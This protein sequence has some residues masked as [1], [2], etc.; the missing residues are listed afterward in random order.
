MKSTWSPKPFKFSDWSFHRLYGSAPKVPIVP[1]GRDISG[2]PVT[3]QSNEA[4]CVSCSVTWI[5]MWQEKNHPDL[6]H[7][8]LAKLSGTTEFGA[9][10]DWVLDTA[11]HI[12]ICTQDVWDAKLPIE[13]QALSA[14]DHKIIAY[15]YLHD[16]RPHSL[17][18]ALGISP[19]MVGV[20][21]YE[22]VGPHMLAA[23]DVSDDGKR[24]KCVN[25]WVQTSQ[26]IVEIPFDKI[27]FACAILEEKPQTK[28]TMN[29]IYVMLSKAKNAIST[30]WYKLKSSLKS[31][32]TRIIA[33]LLVGTGM[34][35]G[36]AGMYGSSG[37]VARFSTTV[38]SSISNTATTIPV[39]SLTLASGETMSTSNVS[40]PLY[41]TIGSGTTI[42]DVEC[43]GI[44]GNTFT[45]CVRGLSWLGGST[46]STV[47]TMRYPHAQ[48]EKV[49]MS[50]TPYYYN[51]FVD[52]PSSQV[53]SGIKNFVSGVTIGGSGATG[54]IAWNGSALTWTNDGVSTYTFDSA[55]PS[56]L[57][58]S[59]TKGIGITDSKIY[60][61]ASSTQG[62]SFDSNGKLFI[63]TSSTAGLAFDSQNRLY[64]SASTTKGL[65]F[66]SEGRLY[67][68]L[69]SSLTTDSSGEIGISDTAFFGDGSDGV[70]DTSSAQTVLDLGGE[71][72]VVKNY[73]SINI[74]TN[75]LILGNPHANGSTLVMKSQGNCV[76][77]SAIYA[78]STGAAGGSAGAA[79]SN[80]AN[81]VAALNFSV[82]TQDGTTLGGVGGV[83]NDSSSGS[84]GGRKSFTIQSFHEHTNIA[85]GSGGAGGAG[86]GV[87]VA[88]GAGGR[89][90]GS[91]VIEC[92]GALNFTG[93]IYANGA[94]GANGGTD[95][96]GGGG[97][98]GGAG[99]SVVILY[100]T[101]TSASGAINING[102]NGG[103][104]G[105]GSGGSNACGAG[106]GGGGSAV[107]G[108]GK[109]GAS[110]TSGTA[111]SAGSAAAI[112]GSGGSAGTGNG[113]GG[114]GGGG[115][116]GYYLV[117]PFLNP[118]ST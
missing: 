18:H 104:G 13:S 10:A 62:L 1:L 3:Y 96:T 97:G 72:Y 95:T 29:P 77:S 68:K 50:N 76:I 89:G 115:A 55:A 67:V 107:S 98:G 83:Y 90:G 100:N 17:Y 35:G 16:L 66:D 44:S 58:A 30:G 106:G 31:N 32:T 36:A 9:E 4:T 99:G 60:I 39:A 94:N 28:L 33:G 19:I 48:G 103:N 45:G 22:G 87:G 53:I 7:E 114:G 118:R 105:N 91:I 81:G 5:K 37:I 26:E 69:S 56:V 74:A 42:E 117:A 70:L 49:I 25:W 46:T 111:G 8:Y 92:G 2:I 54:K 63:N 116:S 112:G 80:G 110:G 27:T 109:S 78:T 21:D 15:A 51:R 75:N 20:A 108:G 6:S 71:K 14:Q 65:G 43:W 113:S 38:A 102:G 47:A 41:L 61:L 11:K 86:G 84:A 85:A 34:V 40:Y 12:G 59:S 24:L 82:I 57:A 23:F 88:G 101:L 79:L 52:I 73:T 93:N 64:L